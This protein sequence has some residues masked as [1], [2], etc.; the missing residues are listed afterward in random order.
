MIK[1]GGKKRERGKSVMFFP[2]AQALK[3]KKKKKGLFY[4]PKYALAWQ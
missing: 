3:K 2:G 4:W 1:S